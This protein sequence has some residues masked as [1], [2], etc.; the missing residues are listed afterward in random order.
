MST[1]EKTEQTEFK[2]QAEIKQLLHLLSHS[3]YQNRDIAMREL[4]SN[5]SDALDK[6]R[7]VALTDEEHRNDDELAIHIEPNKEDRILVIRDNGI[8]MTRD[9]LVKNLGTIAHS[10][11]LEYLNKAAADQK[12]DVS[13]IGQFGVGF[14]SAFML[15]DKVEVITR[16]YAED[17]VWRWE[18][19]GT[20]QFTVDPAEEDS[21]RGTQIRLHLKED[22]DEFTD[23]QRLKH[24]L[25]TY[26][27]FVPHKVYLGDEHV[28]DQ[29]PIWVEPK[30]SLSD[31]QYQHFYQYLSH[32]SDEKPLWHLHLSADSPFQFHAILYCPPSNY[33]LMGFGREEHGISMCAKRVLVQNDCR[34]LLPEYLRFLYGLVDSADLPLNVSREALQDNTVFRKM[35]TVLVKR[36]LDH[37][38]KIADSD[39]EQF[40]TFHKNFGPI[41]REGIS[42]DFANRE[43]IAKLLRFTSSHANDVEKPTSLTQYVE[44]IK[45]GQQQIYFVS[46]PDLAT[47]AQ[48][49]NL[50]IFAKKELEVFYLTDP[51]DEFV[52]S[53]LMRFDG[54]DL[55]SIDS[56][57]VEFPESEDAKDDDD[58]KS[59]DDK[60]DEE[61]PSGF[62]PVLVLFRE[63]LGDRV[64]DVRKSNRLTNS[65]ACLVNSKGTMSTQMQKIMQ[66]SAGSG[67]EMSKLI[68]EVNPRH[69]LL[70]R[71]GQLVSNASQTGFVKDCG[72]QLYSNARVLAGLGPDSEEMVSR[73]QSFMEELA[74][75]RSPIVT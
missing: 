46:G 9:E 72:C 5:A 60:Q 35:Q 54:K 55:T 58:K 31:E 21:P 23:E 2:F 14:Y 67:F 33:E 34:E 36:V 13:L 37:L 65:P 22:M 12:G 17:A 30:S 8:G 50:E 29:P 70:K 62:E 53:T 4:V 66:M 69:P 19:E 7:H 49:P 68:L 6:M 16:S 39:D 40:M 11:S 44:R 52:L 73:V 63:A 45:D 59:D 28:N 3:L 41:I 26:S 47:I 74:N 18:S 10:G 56:A 71:L 32:R 15:A 27:T 24:I 20:G 75:S 64:E 61:L 51:V 42:M 38:A 57:D 48:N 43:R 1:A 25:T